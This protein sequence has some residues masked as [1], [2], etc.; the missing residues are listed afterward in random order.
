MASYRFR[1]TLDGEAVEESYRQLDS[2][3]E[4]L[5]MAEALAFKYDDV[6]L[7]DGNRLLARIHKKKPA[8]EALNARNGG[9]SG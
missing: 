3:M 6:E 8:T 2:D 4:A 7:A 1:L 9:M 5:K